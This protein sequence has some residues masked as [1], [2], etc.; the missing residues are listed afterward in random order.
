MNSWWIRCCIS[1]LTLSGLT[2]EVGTQTCR[3]S[4]ECPAGLVC[5]ANRC[6]AGGGAAGAGGGAG[7]AGGGAAG[8]G[9]AVVDAGSVDGG[10]SLDF[11][12][13]P[14]LLTSGV[15]I[16]GTTVGASNLFNFPGLNGCVLNSTAPDRLYAIDVPAGQRLQSN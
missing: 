11:C 3:T 4:T 6:V 14:T 1:I 16:S 13:S 7:G 10:Q 9:G 15:A 2:C 5:N 12:S 8:A